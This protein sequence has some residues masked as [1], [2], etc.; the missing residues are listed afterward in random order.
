MTGLVERV[1]ETVW[2]DKH[3]CEEENLTR[4]EFYQVYLVDLYLLVFI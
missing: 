1:M 4:I 3:R 2:K